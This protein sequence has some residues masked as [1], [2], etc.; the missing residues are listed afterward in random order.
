MTTRNA[1]LTFAQVR[2][3][4]QRPRRIV[5]LT[6]DAAAAAEVDALDELLDRLRANGAD[7]DQV[8]TV[9][10]ALRDANQAAEASRVEIVLEAVS[11][12]T[13]QEL[14]AAHPATREQIDE[15]KRLG[16]GEPAFDAD[17]F[18]PALVHAQITSPRP[19]SGEEFD[20][21]WAELS[22]GQL[23]RLWDAALAVQLQIAN[24]RGH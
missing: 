21:F 1:P 15:A 17:Q 9:T 20:A 11:H 12:R 4:I 10:A 14:R 19:E 6:L 16:T 23:R 2:D 7:A 5:A 13:Y 8:A 18:A 3:R 24:P 22:D